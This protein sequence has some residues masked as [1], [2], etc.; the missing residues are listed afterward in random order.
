MEVEGKASGG[1]GVPAAMS[2][3]ESQLSMPLMPLPGETMV[4]SL[5]LPSHQWR[6]VLRRCCSGMGR[7]SALEDYNSER[8]GHVASV[9]DDNE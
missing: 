5:G 9:S 2:A 4:P 8:V 7:G 3:E 1:W 6:R